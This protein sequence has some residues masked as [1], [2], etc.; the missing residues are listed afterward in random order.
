MYLLLGEVT[1][2]CCVLVHLV[3]KLLLLS[4]FLEIFF[5]PRKDSRV[6]D[7]P[8]RQSRELINNYTR[9]TSAYLGASKL[10]TCKVS[11]DVALESA[12]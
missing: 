5:Y 9:T 12:T 6:S 7:N 2:D 1:R 4:L 11:M 3:L 10:S 8:K